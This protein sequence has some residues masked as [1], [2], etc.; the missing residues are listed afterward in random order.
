MAR[1]GPGG[2]LAPGPFWPYV[3]QAGSAS[4]GCGRPAPTAFNRAGEKGPGPEA[5]AQG[6]QRGLAP[7][8]NTGSPPPAAWGWL[9]APAAVPGIAAG[10]AASRWRPPAAAA[11][12]QAAS[13][14]VMK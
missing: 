8:G 12:S 10:Q 13:W 4:C 14:T 9:M 3:V 7:D 1:R 11:A 5:A 2:S 6:G